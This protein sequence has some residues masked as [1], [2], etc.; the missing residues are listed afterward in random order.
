MERAPWP[1]VTAMPVPELELLVVGA[2]V[3]VPPVVGAEVAVPPIAGADVAVPVVP[4][5]EPPPFP[6]QKLRMAISQLSGDT[7]KPGMF[8]S[9]NT[10]ALLSMVTSP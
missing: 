4:E 9:S 7:P 5:P 1:P 3:A 10:G 6:F 2:D 8:F